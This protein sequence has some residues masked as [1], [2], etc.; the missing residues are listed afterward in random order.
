VVKMNTTKVDVSD[1]AT[2]FN[3]VTSLYTSKQRGTDSHTYVL[4]ASMLQTR[5]L[6][7]ERQYLTVSGRNTS[8]VF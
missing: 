8:L 4:T 1:S 6:A 3:R 2:K 7:Q 5:I